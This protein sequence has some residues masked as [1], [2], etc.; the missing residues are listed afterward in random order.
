MQN[1]LPELCEKLDDWPIS[2]LTQSPF[3]KGDQKTWVMEYPWV[4]YS[5][6]QRLAMHS[7]WPGTPADWTLTIK[8]PRG[9]SANGKHE[10]T[11]DGNGQQRGP[12]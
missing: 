2:R 1:L 4:G 12:L 10:I 7:R 6:A 11:G 5:M 8:Y 9:A 3:E